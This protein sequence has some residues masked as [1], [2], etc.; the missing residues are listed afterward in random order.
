MARGYPGVTPPPGMAADKCIMTIYTDISSDPKS[1]PF[2]LT[3]LET[4]ICP[5]IL[6][7]MTSMRLFSYESPSGKPS[8]VTAMFKRG[9]RF[10]FIQQ[11]EMI[12]GIYDLNS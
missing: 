10:C 8:L 11:T 7:K 2:R 9:K 3:T 4:K 6:S 1:Y 12:V 5:P